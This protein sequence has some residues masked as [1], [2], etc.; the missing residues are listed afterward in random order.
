M[1]LLKRSEHFDEAMRRP[2]AVR[3]KVV[4]VF[5]IPCAEHEDLPADVVLALQGWELRVHRLECGHTMGPY[6]LRQG[7]TSLATD[8]I[9]WQCQKTGAR[10]RGGNSRSPTGTSTP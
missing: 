6:L 8:L 4:D 5:V 3:R 7:R 1:S 2:K 9:C 10:L